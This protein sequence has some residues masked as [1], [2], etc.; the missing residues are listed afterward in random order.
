M[1]KI[2]SAQ[3]DSGSRSAV[4]FLHGDCIIFM[5]QSSN[6]FNPAALITLIAYVSLQN[7]GPHEVADIW[8]AGLYG[9]VPQ[10]RI[11]LPLYYFYSLCQAILPNSH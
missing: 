8:G 5:M 3:C 11:M 7:N 2:S 10:T 9:V 4:V 6:V 1:Y